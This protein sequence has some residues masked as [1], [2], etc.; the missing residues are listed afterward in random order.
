[1]SNKYERMKIEVSKFFPSCPLCQK[2]S[3]ETR[4]N[5]DWYGRDYIV[6]SNCQAK[7]H[8][9]YLQELK[10]AELVNVGASN[11]GNDYLNQRYEPTFWFDKVQNKPVEKTITPQPIVK[12][13]EIVR[14]KEVIVK[15]KCQY[16]GKLYNEVLDVCPHCGG[17]R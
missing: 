1:M 13:K 3:I 11:K 4:F 10:W 5:D 9:Y 17:K 16:C 12:E 14:E 6:C 15:V 8:I 2:E 7:W